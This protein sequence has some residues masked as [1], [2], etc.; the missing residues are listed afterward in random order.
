MQRLRSQSWRAV[1]RDRYS[2]RVQER[3]MFRREGALFAIEVERISLVPC[4]ELLEDHVVH[5][6]AGVTSAVA[7]MV[8]EH[9]SM[10][11]RAKSASPAQCVAS[12]PPGA[13]A[14]AGTTCC[15]RAPPRDRSQQDPH[16]LVFDKAWP[17]HHISATCR[18][19]QQARRGA[20]HVAFTCAASP[21]LLRAA[22]R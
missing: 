1:G 15:R 19:V 21:S 4:L 12:T 9:L 18:D 22:R 17:F 3:V 10:C 20:T 11:R 16:I 2:L 7:R 14:G 13:F 6:R 8:S 5:L